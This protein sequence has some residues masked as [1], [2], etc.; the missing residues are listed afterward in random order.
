VGGAKRID[1]EGIVL[2]PWRAE[3]AE[4]LAS[5]ADDRAIWRNLR[6]RFPHPYRVADAEASLASVA[7]SRWSSPSSS[8]AQTSLRGAATWA[9][10][11]PHRSDV[12]SSGCVV[13]RALAGWSLL[14][15]VASEVVEP[16]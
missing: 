12:V 7:K 15:F 4:R 6:D 10:H 5:L 2:R 8:E 11:R 9:T 14:C 16:L 3:E 13:R 1:L